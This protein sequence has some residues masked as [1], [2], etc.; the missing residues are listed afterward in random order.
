MFPNIDNIVRGNRRLPDN[1]ARDAYEHPIML[2][3][4]FGLLSPRMTL[5]E[6]L[7]TDDYW[8]E[9]IGLTL[10]DAKGRF[11]QAA[12]PAD[13]TAWKQRVAERDYWQEQA[14]DT[15]ELVPLNFDSLSTPGSAD[16]VLLS[17]KMGQLMRAGTLDKIITAAY[18]SLKPGGSL[19]I[20]DYRASPAMPQDPKAVSDYISEDYAIATVQKAGFKLTDRDDRLLANPKDTKTKAAVDSDRFLLKFTK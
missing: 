6:V 17:R 13:E 3:A 4:S 14:A 10:M 20:A 16:L 9:Y 1:Y 12:D 18:K 11:L 8:S 19:L 5:I 2:M 15:I 7:P